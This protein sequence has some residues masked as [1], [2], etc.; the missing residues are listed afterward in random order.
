MWF[1]EG[2]F[3]F[4]GDEPDAG[5]GEQFEAHVVVISVHSSF[6]SASTAPTRRISAAREG[7]IPTTSVRRRIF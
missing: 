5:F 2:G 7:K 3:G 4:G 6:C 1:A